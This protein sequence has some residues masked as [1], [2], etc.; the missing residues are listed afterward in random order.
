VLF[1]AEE[2]SLG[3]FER[4][5]LRYI[6]GAVRDKS[7]CRKRYNY[8]LYKVFNEPDVI[9]HSKISRLSWAAHI[10]HMENSRTV[11]V[12]FDT[13]PERTRKIGRPKLRWEDGVTQDIRALGVKN[14]RNM[15]IDREDWW[16]LLK[17]AKVHTGLKPMMMMM[18]MNN[19]SH[20]FVTL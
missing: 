4:R 15:A 8:E 11:K 6:F 14:W 18:M 10:I 9:K 17:E 1:K 20:L 19:A 12:V 3:L 13:R 2:R 5:V 7:A 16:K